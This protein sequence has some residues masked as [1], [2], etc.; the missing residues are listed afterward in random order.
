MSPKRRSTSQACQFPLCDSSIR[1]G[2]IKP[3]EVGEAKER[4][5]QSPASSDQDN[6]SGA[7]EARKALTGS[8]RGA[9][10]SPGTTRAKVGKPQRGK[11]STYR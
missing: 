1:L 2:L 6:P 5:P 4:L 8:G 10:Q 11:E 9:Q 7:A 3:T